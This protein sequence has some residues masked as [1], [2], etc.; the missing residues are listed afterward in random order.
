MSFG[1]VLGE[2]LTRTS[3]RQRAGKRG[4]RFIRTQ[5]GYNLVGIEL[6]PPLVDK[7]LGLGDPR[8]L[9]KLRGAGSGIVRLASRSGNLCLLGPEK[10]IR[11]RFVM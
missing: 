2:R 5:R 10:N 11:P 3:L 1:N 7:T 6:S 4:D 9:V 8:R